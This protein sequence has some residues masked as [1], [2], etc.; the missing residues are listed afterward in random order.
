MKKKVAI[1]LT[2]FAEHDSSPL[3]LLE[4]KGFEAIKNDFGRKLSEEETLKLCSGCVGIIAGTET[5]DKDILKKLAT[6]KSISR[7]GVGIENIDI[8]SA[9]KLGIMIF[10]TPDAPTLAVAELTLGLILNLLRKI[11]QMDAALKNGEWKKL[12]GNLLCGKKVGIIG[13]GRIGQK[14]AQLLSAFALEL[15]YTDIQPKSCST[16]CKRMTLE[17]ILAWA[18]ILTLHLSSDKQQQPIIGKKEISLMKKASFLVNLSRGGM[19]DEQALYEGLKSGHLQGA[20]LDVFHQEPYF[21]PLKELDNVILTPHIGSYA[22][23]ARIKMEFQAVKN[24]LAG[25]NDKAN[26]LKL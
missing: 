4:N 19:V 5:Y 25:L 2:S 14:V 6:V 24:L 15:A 16:R 13:F 11:N 23:E 10:S 22:K 3:Q 18:D 1:T 21:G 9:E 12:M 26:L 17:E 7:C 20:A 8:E